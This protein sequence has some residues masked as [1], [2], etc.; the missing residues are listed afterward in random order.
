MTARS[1]RD[2]LLAIPGIEDAEID[3]D[4]VAPAGVTVR[5]APGIDSAEVSRDVQ[6]VLAAHG[7]RSE[8]VTPQPDDAAAAPL[9]LAEPPPPDEA[10]PPHRSE[11]AR[12][13]VEVSIHPARERVLTSVAVAEQRSGMSVVLLGSDGSAAT[14]TIEAPE[15]ELEERI[16]EA[17]IEAV[18]ELLDVSPPRLIEVAVREVAGSRVVTVLLERSGLRMVGSAVAPGTRAYAVGRAAWVALSPD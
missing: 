7:L 6:R 13:R 15:G 14:R 9:R 2:D 18:A 11:P 16:D 4:S 17:V 5:M 1:L 8:M 3:G 12:P 10:A